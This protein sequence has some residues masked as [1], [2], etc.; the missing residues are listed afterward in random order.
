[1]SD[2]KKRVYIETYGCQ[3]NV[4][5][6]E[7]VLGLLA[8]DGVELTDSIEDADALF[9]N[10][11]SVR[12]NA[13]Q[14]VY[15]RLGEFKRMKSRKPGVVVGVLGCMA[16]RLR[17]KLRGEKA[18]GVGQAVDLIIGPDEYR[19]TPALLRGAWH[20]EKG[21]AVRLSRV[22]TYDDITPLRTE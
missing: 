20:G 2:L 13:E 18:R 22:E 14:R 9:V 5:D 19:K 3:M 10:T 11:C 8:E 17:V 21:I 4:A 6:T 12:E 15:G 16:E 7:V 1:M